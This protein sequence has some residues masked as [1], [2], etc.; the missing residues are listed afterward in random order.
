VLGKRLYKTSML[1]IF[2]FIVFALILF[3]FND[4][5]LDSITDDRFISMVTLGG[6]RGRRILDFVEFIIKY[7]GDLISFIVL[8]CVPGFYF[9]FIRGVG[10]FEKGIIVNRGIPFFNQTLS[11]DD[12]K[13]YR[14]LHPKLA[15]SIQTKN[16]DAFVVADENIE[17]AIAILDQHNIQG[18]LNQGEFVKILSN[19]K[20]FVVFFSVIVIVLYVVRK[21]GVYFF[22]S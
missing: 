20:K 14:L 5:Y 9:A 22:Y 17:R 2:K 3:F 1:W 21:L 10:F 15:I 13:T 6:S 18:D 16:G 7:P 11:Y 19:Y 8:Y 12:V 4:F